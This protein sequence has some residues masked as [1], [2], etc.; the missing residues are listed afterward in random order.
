MKLYHA[1]GFMVCATILTACMSSGTYV[2]ANQVSQF[3]KGETT[4]DQVEKALGTPSSRSILYNGHTAIGYTYVEATARP[5]SFI[6]LVGGLVGGSD[7]R[8]TMASFVFDENGVLTTSTYT[9]SQNGTGMGFN[10]G[11]HNQKIDNTPRKP[12]QSPVIVKP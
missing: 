6:P 7:S 10:S 5:A 1:A 9:G 3:K 12:E 4:I 2:D 11:V 8:M